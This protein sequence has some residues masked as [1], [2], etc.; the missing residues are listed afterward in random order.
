MGE[1]TKKMS[2]L[3]T[4]Q[5]MKRRWNR[6]FNKGLTVFQMCLLVT[7]VI[8]AFQEKAFLVLF[9]MVINL[10]AYLEPNQYR[11]SLNGGSKK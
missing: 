8:G 9:S 4:F 1:K 11:F 3:T 5:L 6:N 2:K 7:M 10:F